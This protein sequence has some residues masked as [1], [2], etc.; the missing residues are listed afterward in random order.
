MANENA[1][2]M[3]DRPV[4]FLIGPT[5]AGKTD[6]AAAL[7][8]R[9][10]EFG[11]VEFGGAE[12]VNVDATQIYRGMDVG[13]AKPSAD[14]LRRYPHHLIDIRDIRDIRAPAQTYNA[15]DFCA[16]AHALIQSIRARGK[17]PVLVGGSM[18][19]F[20]ALE[21]GLSELPAACIDAR[22]AISR[23][24]EQHGLAAMH[25][26]LQRIDA[27]L[28]SA[29]R[30]SDAQRIGRALE[31]HRLTGRAPSAVMRGARPVPFPYPLLK[32]GVFLADRRRL[33][34]RIE[35]RFRRMV[36]CGL[37]DEVRAL[38]EQF[39]AANPPPAFRAV[40]YR[41]ALDYLR[42]RLK[43]D[44]MLAKG[45][46][47]TRQL[48]KRQLTWMRAQRDLV[49]VEVSTGAGIERAVDGIC[50]HLHCTGAAGAGIDR[51]T[52]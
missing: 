26:E 40:G 33:H 7:F 1:A 2:R 17:L 42:G 4:I 52:N 29:I 32:F 34:A 5:A 36:E 47:A 51:T 43:H 49:W 50:A 48:A 46:A 16:D 41:Q 23:D 21:H 22:A 27:A 8:D 30:P 13:S 3:P 19:Y 31:I 9:V 44:E 39:D 24:I 14:F 20:A 12:L 38:A 37:V 11:G 35:A 15:A 45:I 6:L 28:A 18:F 10:A 25:A